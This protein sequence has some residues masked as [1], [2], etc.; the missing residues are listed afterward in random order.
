VNSLYIMLRLHGIECDY[1]ALTDELYAASPEGYNSMA[2]LK[3]SAARRGLEL[4]VGRTSPEALLELE[5][6]VIAHIEPLE[7]GGGGHF[8][9]VLK[10]DADTVQ[11]MDGTTG[12]IMSRPW[13]EFAGRWSGHVLYPAP[14][15]PRVQVW[16]GYGVAV[17][18][19]VGLAFILTVAVPL[20][21]V[22]R[23]PAAETA[24]DAPHGLFTN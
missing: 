3:R 2:D 9:V 21:R 18:L 22:Q 20:R 16:A 11:T 5:K 23:Q 4:E 24:A 6:P 8:V 10:T 15:T 12:N 19:G 1:H 17:L 13:R 14:P 7:R